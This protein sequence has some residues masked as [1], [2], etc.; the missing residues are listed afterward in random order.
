MGSLHF[1]QSAG[2]AVF[3]L[4]GRAHLGVVHAGQRPEPL[5]V[6]AARVVD[7]MFFHCELQRLRRDADLVAAVDELNRRGRFLTTLPIRFPASDLTIATSA[8]RCAG[9]ARESTIERGAR[10]CGFAADLVDA[11]VGVRCERGDDREAVEGDAVTCPRSTF[12]ASSA[13]RPVVAASPFMM[14]APANTS[15]VLASTY[16]PVTVAGFAASAPASGSTMRPKGRVSSWASPLVTTCSSRG[17]RQQASGRT[18]WRSGPRPVC[19]NTH[20]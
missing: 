5:L 2:A 11:E 8:L 4:G 12:H 1:V 14:Q 16:V 13:S 17:H 15:A 19:V 10:G 20:H 3:V 18:G 7:E 9:V 6:A